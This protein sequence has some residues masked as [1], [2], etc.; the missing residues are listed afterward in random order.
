MQL[1]APCGEGSEGAAAV[2][3]SVGL[4]GPGRM[5]LRAQLS[6][7]QITPA[8][9]APLWKLWGVIYQTPLPTAPREDLHSRPLPDPN[10][11][12]GRREGAKD[13]KESQ[14]PRKIKCPLL[15]APVRGGRER[16]PR[17]ASE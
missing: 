11:V 6:P 12:R 2:G 4:A 13:T 5:N 1:R 16:G 9:R 8:W 17:P 7:P 14:L 15:P 10:E 3:D